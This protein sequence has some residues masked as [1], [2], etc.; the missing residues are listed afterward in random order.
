M[1]K[2]LTSLKINLQ[3]TYYFIVQRKNLIVRIN[4]FFK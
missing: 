2:S 4:Y 3:K 1:E